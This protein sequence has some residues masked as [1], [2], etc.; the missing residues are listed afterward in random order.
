LKHPTSICST[1]KAIIVDIEPTTVRRGRSLIRAVVTL[2]ARRSS[3][4]PGASANEA[5][6]QNKLDLAASALSPL[7]G[8]ADLT[9]GALFRHFLPGFGAPSG[10]KSCAPDFHAGC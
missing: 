7:C 2:R 4:S 1:P 9:S 8:G 3:L 6:H 10:R 5:E